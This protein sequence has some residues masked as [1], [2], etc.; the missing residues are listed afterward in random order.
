MTR[1][2]QHCQKALKTIGNKRKNGKKDLEDYP[3]RKYHKKCLEYINL[4][5]RLDECIMGRTN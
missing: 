5:K 4:L 1:T 3:T 2:C